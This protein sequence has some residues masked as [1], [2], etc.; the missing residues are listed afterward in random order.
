[1]FENLNVLVYIFEKYNLEKLAQGE[2]NCLIIIKEY[3]LVI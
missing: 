3:E 2:Y 1:M